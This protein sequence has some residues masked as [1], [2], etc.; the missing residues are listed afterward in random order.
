MPK[1]KKEKIAG[2]EKHKQQ[3]REK[4]QKRKEK[5]KISLPKRTKKKWF[6]FQLLDSNSISLWYFLN[7]FVTVEKI[8]INKNSIAFFIKNMSTI[9][10]IWENK[11]WKLTV[12]DFINKNRWF[13]ETV[14]ARV[15]KSKN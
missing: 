14:D 12:F 1:S 8:F 9:W 10:L 3:Q 11:D 4:E 5:R 2:L 15:F 13:N 7:F 6:S